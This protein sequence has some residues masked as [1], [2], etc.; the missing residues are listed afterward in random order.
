MLVIGCAPTII[1][2]STGYFSQK[3]FTKVAFLNTIVFVAI[4]VTWMLLYYPIV[5]SMLGLE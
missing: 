2:Y 3:D 1:A 5:L 4:T